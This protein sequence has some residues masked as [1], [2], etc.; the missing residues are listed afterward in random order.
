FRARVVIPVKPVALA[1]YNPKH[2]CRGGGLAGAGKICDGRDWTGMLSYSGAADE[3]RRG[4][5]RRQQNLGMLR[6]TGGR[7]AIR[8]T[9]THAG[10]ISAGPGTGSR[11]RGACP[12]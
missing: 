6:R 7:I 8:R 3:G 4:A 11:S 1:V 10:L 12:K 2:S 5:I 9:R